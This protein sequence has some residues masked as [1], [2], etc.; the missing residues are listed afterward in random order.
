MP[1]PRA[2]SSG[3]PVTSTLDHPCA[4]SLFEMVFDSNTALTE[5]SETEFLRTAHRT[6][7]RHLRQSHPETQLSAIPGRTTLPF[8]T[9]ICCSQMNA[10]FDSTQA[11][12]HTVSD[13]AQ[14][15]PTRRS[16]ERSTARL[17]Q[18]SPSLAR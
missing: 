3:S 5:H 18:G 7:S 2:A 8:A 14:D 13:S 12:H 10:R 15:D 1:A 11:R 6:S 17:F 16:T 4:N 9:E